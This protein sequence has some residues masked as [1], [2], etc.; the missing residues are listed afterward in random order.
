M[1]NL[2]LSG[3]SIDVRFKMQAYVMSIDVS[4]F[5]YEHIVREEPLFEQGIYWCA[6][7]GFEIPRCRIAIIGT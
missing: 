2:S 7:H 5:G 6:V 4:C 3:G 1:V